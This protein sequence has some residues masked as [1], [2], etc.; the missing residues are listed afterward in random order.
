MQHFSINFFSLKELNGV[1]D[2]G[3]AQNNGDIILEFISIFDFSITGQRC[4]SLP[5]E[6]QYSKEMEERLSLFIEKYKQVIPAIQQ[7][8]KKFKS[9]EYGEYFYILPVCEMDSKM[10]YTLEKE[11]CKLNKKDFLDKAPDLT[12]KME[13]NLDKYNIEDF[14]LD[15]DSK[16]KIGEGKKEDRVCK[17]CKQKYPSVKF[18]SVAHTISE[19][20]GNKKLITNDECDECNSYFDKNIERDFIA[21]HDFLRTFFRIKNK[22]NQI[23]QMSG[24]NFSFTTN[25][26][27][28][29]TLKLKDE[30]DFSQPA[31]L[32]IGNKIKMQN[33][34]KAL[35]K[36]ALSAIDSKHLSHFD[37]TIKWIKGQK[38]VDKLPKVILI[39]SPKPMPTNISLYIRKLDEMTIPRLVGVFDFACF[40]Y[41]FIV[42]TFCE[43]DFIDEKEYDDFLECFSFIKDVN[44]LKFIDFSDNQE[45]EVVFNLNFHKM[46]CEFI[47]KNF[48][49]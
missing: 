47:D 13:K 15:K 20:L 8:S 43:Q 33:I 37:E 2:I 24:K 42:P 48:I 39:R 30:F 26:N 45:K 44:S 7:L 18:N 46:N 21:Y 4:I 22:E 1:C 34:Y 41:V 28:E 10:E 11:L 12:I 17:F 25:E 6:Q 23:P 29:A 5:S 35:C 36:F 40:R 32:K 27:R 3:Y 49:R 9:L 31:R 19:A 38:N 16:I 14:N